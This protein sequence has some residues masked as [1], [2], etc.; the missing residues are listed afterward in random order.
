MTKEAI[1]KREARAKE[2]KTE[3]DERLAKNAKRNMDKKNAMTDEE[4]KSFLEKKAEQTKTSR[5]G[6]SEEKT[7]ER[8]EANRLRQKA[9]RD[10]EKAAKSANLENVTAEFQ[11]IQTRPRSL[12]IRP[13]VTTRLSIEGGLPRSN[14]RNP[15]SSSGLNDSISEYEKLR[16]R[17]I[18]ERQQKFMS[19][20]GYTD[21]LSEKATVS[22]KQKNKMRKFT[23]Q[24]NNTDPDFVANVEPTTSR[25]V[26][27]RNC[28]QNLAF[29]FDNDS[30][31]E[32]LADLVNEGHLFANTAHLEYL[33]GSNL[34]DETP[35]DMSY[36]GRQILK[37]KRR[38][39][40]LDR[41]SKKAKKSQ[42]HR[43]NETQDQYN[44][45]LEQSAKY[46]RNLPT[47]QVEKRKHVRRLKR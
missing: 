8:N 4:R 42:K 10:A 47:Y 28:T 11:R 7:K 24:I 9:K 5:A 22:N 2:S 16:D 37:K 20:F 21:P 14:D 38:K 17:N 39:A 12:I 15:S 36:G 29:N 45:R 32:K 33:Y 25:T 6:E 26:P 18:L 3:T 46:N 35:A 41:K 23:S 44:K 43:E 31:A 30:Y 19:H 13:T 27:R 34:M 1:R 40:N